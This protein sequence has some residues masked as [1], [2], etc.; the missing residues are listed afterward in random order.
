MTLTEVSYYGRK[1]LPFVFIFFLIFIALFYIVR[2]TFLYSQK[3]KTTPLFIKPTFGKIA[4]PVIKNATASGQFNFTLD[5]IEGVPVTATPSANVFFLPEQATRFGY[6]E[7]IYLMAK[8][9]G[10]DTENVKHKLVDKVATFTDDRQKLTI[11]ITNFNFSYE[12]K[13]AT[14]AAVFVN[15]RIPERTAIEESATGTLKA[16]GRYPEELSKGKTNIVYFAY[17]ALSNTLGVTTKPNEANVVEVD[18][19]R[20]DI[21]AFPQ[22]LSVVSP[23]YFTSQNYVIL[24]FNDSGAKIL[25][26]QVRF[27]EK[28]PDQVGVYPL[29]TGDEVWNNLKA[30]KGSIISTSLSQGSV[31]IK[32]MFLAYFDP[33]EYQQYLQPV[34][35]FLGDN[36]FIAYVQALS[37]LYL[38]D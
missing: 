16:L 14:D 21:D 27:F 25:K 31:T 7:K 37:S 1:L 3:T 11:D 23:K 8:T 22:A 19:Y 10:F 5:T 13:Y 26:A 34:Y 12:Y 30:G 28:S 15:A 18:Y 20:P 6:R 4:A 24:V 29:K 36:D 17:N 32:K 33:D 38:G 35:V 9:I 2:I